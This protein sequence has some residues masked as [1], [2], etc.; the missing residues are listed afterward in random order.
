MTKRTWVLIAGL[1]SAGL[2]LAADPPQQVYGSQL[3]TQQE[4]AAYRSKM[5]AAKTAEDKMRV[6][7]EHH[8]QMQKRAQEQGLT[9]PDTPPE[10]GGGMGPGGGMGMGAPRNR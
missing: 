2:V 5:R 3:M 8:E 1:M 10:V 9:L 7:A 4:R 6:R